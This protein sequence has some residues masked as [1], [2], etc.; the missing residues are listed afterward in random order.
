[1]TKIIFIYPPD[2]RRVY[3]WCR[4]DQPIGPVRMEL[5][6]MIVTICKGIVY[7]DDDKELPQWFAYTEDGDWHSYC[8]ASFA[9]TPADAAVA[10]YH[11][12]ELIRV[13][14]EDGKTKAEIREY[15]NTPTSKLDSGLSNIPENQ[16]A[17]SIPNQGTCGDVS[18]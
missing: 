9:A 5:N 18:G 3:E 6:A 4:F 11:A 14:E 12:D 15:G 7:D 1:M 2:R 13:W 16:T 10:M 8:D 17:P